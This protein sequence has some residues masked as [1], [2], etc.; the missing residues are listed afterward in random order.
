MPLAGTKNKSNQGRMAG[1]RDERGPIQARLGRQ[2]GPARF[3]AVPGSQISPD[4]P[5]ADR[6]S[7]RKP[8]P[9]LPPPPRPPTARRATRRPQRRAPAG[10]R[11]VLAGA[12]RALVVQLAA[13]PDSQVRLLDLT[14]R[15]EQCAA[16]QRL[17]ALEDDAVEDAVL[18]FE[19]QRCGLRAAEFRRARARASPSASISDGP[20]VQRTRSRLQPVSSSDSPTP[21]CRVRRSRAAGRE[22]PTRHSKDSERR[23]V[24]TAPE[25][26]G[27]PARCRRRRSRCRSLRATSCSPSGSVT[28]NRLS[29][30]QLA[31]TTSTS[32]SSTP[33]YS[34]SCSREIRRNS[35]GIDAVTAEEPVDGVRRRIA[36]VA[37][38]AHEH[39]PSASTEDECGAQAGRSGPH[40]DDVV[41][42]IMVS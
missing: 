19:T 16:R 5:G 40:N 15:E 41:H 38:V 12:D 21:R 36:R 23:C 20:S 2:V 3:G 13:E 14:R 34:R 24:R 4:L 11:L 10:G 31:S 29:A 26:R 8:L 37:G 33:S 25:A 39:A 17:A 1:L 30:R 27:S 28:S 35:R 6:C 22:L 7:S 18:S 42:A 32:R 9:L